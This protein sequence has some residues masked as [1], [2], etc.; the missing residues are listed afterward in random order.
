MMRGLFQSSFCVSFAMLSGSAEPSCKTVK[1]VAK[2]AI[3]NDSNN[4]NSS[5]NSSSNSNV[6]S[7]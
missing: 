1:Q 4:S 5:S 6:C 3:H 7:E 2:I